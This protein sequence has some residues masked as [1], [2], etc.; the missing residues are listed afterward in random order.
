MEEKR[1]SFE[2][3]RYWAIEPDVLAE[4]LGSSRQGLTNAEAEL[5]RTPVGER[6]SIQ[7]HSDIGLLLRQF[8]SPLILLLVAASAVSMALAERV[9]S[10]IILAIV[11]ASGLLGFAQERGAVRAIEALRQLVTVHVDI[12]RDGRLVEMRVDDVVSGDVVRLDAGDVIP[13]DCIILESNRLTV[14]ESVLT[15]EAFPVRKE[16]GPVDP[17]ATLGDRLNCLYLGSHVSSGSATA[18]VVLVGQ[19]TEFGS[20]EQEV[21]Q[22]HLPTS[23]ERGVT[24]YGL[25]L[26][27]ATAVLVFGVFALNL[28][29]DRGVSESVLF[30]LALAVGLAPQML[31]AIVT[32]S[33]SIGARV[34]A[35]KK[36]VVKRLDAIEDFGSVDVLCTDKTGTLTEGTVHVHDAIDM[37]C[38][39]SNVVLERAYWNAHLQEGHSNPIDDAISNF[40]GHGVAL[41]VRLAEVPFD[42]TRKIVSVVVKTEDDQLL[43]CKGAVEQ[44]MSRCTRVLVDGRIEPIQQHAA[45]AHRS[46]QELSSQGLRLLGVAEKSL[47]VNFVVEDIS[48][49]DLTLLGF[50]AFVDPPKEGTRAAID[51]L[52]ESGVIVKIITGDNREITKI[53]AGKVGI[54]DDGMLTGSEILALSDDELADRVDETNLFVEVD[55]LQKER[56]VRAIS[57]RGHTV[58]FVGDGVN[59]VAALHAADVGISVDSGVDVA[60]ATA[61]LILLD[62]S[63]SVINEGI[64]QGRRVFANTLKYVYVTTSANFG[65]M[66]SLACA[67]AFLPFLPM[68]P[69]QILLLNFLSD[70]PGMTIAT[71][72]V[73]LERLAQP[74]RWD[75]AQVRRFMIVFGL[76]STSVDLATFA[77]LRISFDSDAA[78]LRTGWFL[79]SVLTEVVALLFLRTSKRMYRGHPSRPL[80]TSSIAIVM[81]TVLLVLTP[82]GN[83]FRLVVLD[84]GL[85]VVLIGLIASYA[86]LTEI[87]KSRMTLLF[88]TNPQSAVQR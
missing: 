57:S 6:L 3:G 16:P 55:P 23:F 64:H 72:N 8:R 80:L 77:I 59:D 7:S 27:K 75:I 38:H 54:H 21:A 52:R 82:L 20:I 30:S 13:G 14:D 49:D 36:V 81:M 26:I 78:E 29:L 33:L 67:T 43:I 35:T 37:N 86:L 87:L 63:L 2:S 47:P 51:R 56:I 83:P 9:D 32:L 46:F 70:V 88:H 12:I 61:D 48:E 40:V 79:V 31:P 60:K 25:L 76:L 42:F 22:R 11:F 19:R 71:D 4:Q 5:R 68:L 15:G 69:L 18:L 50:V 44:V 65:N 66:V 58:G 10:L 17:N 84:G 24:A 62:K 28:W 53:T 41:P 1:T 85:M 34:L 39:T 73:D 74:Q 45:T